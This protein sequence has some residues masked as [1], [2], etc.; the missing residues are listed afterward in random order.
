MIGLPLDPPE[1]EILGYCEFSTCKDEI[2][3]AVYELITYAPGVN[4]RTVTRGHAVCVEQAARAWITD[5]DLDAMADG[6]WPEVAA[7]D[8][9]V[10][11]CGSCGR[12][13]SQCCCP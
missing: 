5:M 2:T 3:D 6:N 12:D 9:E 8:P 10:L 1:A 11:K 4:G 7:C 13:G